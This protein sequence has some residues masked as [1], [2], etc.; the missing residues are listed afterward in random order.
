MIYALDGIAP[1]I[2]PTAWIAPDANVIGRVRIGP[3]ASVW[4]G[5]T[6]RGDMELIEVGEGSNVQEASVLH[7][8][9]GFPLSIGSGVTVGHKAML[10]GCTVEEGALVGMC[11][12]MLNG[13]TL[14]A[15]ALLG[16]GAL[17]TEGKAIPEEQLALGSPAK[18]IRALDDA[19]VDGLR[20]SAQH[21]AA[22]ARRFAQGLE[23]L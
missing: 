23:P 19:A 12:T 9:A 3:G 8:D 7:T 1:E 5:A 20:L 17:L 22:N 15:R 14:G 18:A 16:A 2:H 21:Y 11:V 6:L 10:H 4:F 13:S